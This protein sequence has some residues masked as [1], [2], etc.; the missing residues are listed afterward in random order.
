MRWA[1][2]QLT[3]MRTALLL[4]LLLTVAAVPGSLVPQ[5]G[6]DPVRVAQF[7]QQHPELGRWYDRLSLFDVYSAP[8]FA[9]IYLLLLVSLAGCV[10]PRSQLHWSAARAR[11]PAP[12]R[13]LSRLEGFHAWRAHGAVEDSVDTAGEVLRRAGYRVDR[14]PG[15][16][17]AE[18][19]YLRETGNLLFHS[20][21]LLLLGA[22]AIGNLWGYQGQVL[23]PEGG[24]FSNTIPAYDTFKHGAAFGN[25][26]LEPFTVTLDDLDVRYQPDGDQRGAPRAF[27]ASLRYTP[28]PDAP[29]RRYR[30]RVN[31]PLDVGGAKVFLIGNGY[32]PVFTVR[33]ATG[34]VVFSGAVP[35]LPRDG[36][37][38]STGVVKAT[39]AQPQQLGFEGLFLP[40]AAIHP[41]R[42]PISVYPDLSL[43]RA[44]L[45]AWVGDLGLDDGA[46]QS[47][48]RL[49]KSRMKQVTVGGR[50]LAQS[51]APGTTMTL[52]NGT[53]S[54]TFDGVQRWATLQVSHD[55][56]RMPALLA[57]VLA[58][59][60]LMLSLFVRRRRVWVRATTA[61]DGRTLVEVAGLSRREGDDVTD[62]LAQ[63]NDQLR[64]R[65]EDHRPAEPE[66]VSTR[67]TQ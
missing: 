19:G 15:A 54:I 3:S 53:G 41:E 47:V 56:G 44:V 49:D 2:S 29:P 55:P 45:T 23:V 32:A 48:Y 37:N 9:A 38:T 33:D 35:F 52:P 24:S 17:S 20:A 27:V 58:L 31:H 60:G 7:K 43:P 42:G 22:V 62:E 30:L 5:T 8:W 63:L 36:N 1:W 57:A 25:G 16:V 28:Q 46:P 67:R 51:L 12:P 21:L 11:P 18:K 26:A 10:I 14:H 40:S 50:P 66:Q 13:N 59:S 6:V 4:L 64:S 65:L 39:G 61:D 34:E